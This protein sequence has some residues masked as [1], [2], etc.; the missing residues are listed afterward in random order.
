[1][2]TLLQ[3][4]RFGARLLFK[5]RGFTAI[6]V[7]TLALGIGPNMAIFSVINYILLNPFPFPNSNQLVAVWEKP[8]G[9]ERNEVAPANFLD[10]STQSD[11]F[12]SMAALSFWNANLTGPSLPERLQGFQVSPSLFPMLDTKPLMGRYFL[13]DEDTPGR[14]TVVILSHALWQNRFGSDPSI[15]NQTITLNGIPHTVV[16][17][18]PPSF[19]IYRR[20][21]L[22]VPL[23][24]TQEDRASRDFHFLIVIGRLKPSVTITQA[25]GEMDSIANRLQQLYPSTNTD[26]GIRLID[27]FDQTVVN[28]R[29]A[30]LM[31]LAA[32]AFVL[33]IAC[34]NLANLLLAR[35]TA[36][37]REIAIRVAL[38]SSRV[39]LVRQLL[40]ESVLLS[41]LGGT[42]GT[43]IAVWGIKLLIARIP[44]DLLFTVP[45]LNEIGVDG[46]ALAFTVAI[47]VLTG[48][49]FGLAPALHAS[50]PN[51]TES[52]KEGGRGLVGDQHGRVLRSGLVVSEIAV[53]VVLLVSIGL[54]I[55]SFVQ[56]LNVDTGF[57]PRN[58]LT[59]DFSLSG[60]KYEKQ[61]PPRAEFYR[62]VLERVE[63]VPGVQSVGATSNLPLGGTNLARSF[64]IEDFPVSDP[65]NT[66]SI[67]YRVVSP[68]YFRTLGIPLVKGRDFSRQDVADAPGV[69]IINESTMRRY[70][71]DQEPLGR[72][73][74][75]GPPSSPRPWLAIVGVVKDVKHVGLEEAPTAEVYL[76]YQQNPLT[77]MTLVARTVGDPMSIVTAVRGE[78]VGVDKEQPVYNVR[79]MEQVMSDSVPTQKLSVMLVGVFGGV[80][81]LLVTVGVYG[82]MSYTI[83]QRKR[84][85]GIRMALGAKPS[86]VVKMVLAQ[87]MLLVI[88][89]LGIGIALAIGVAWLL[90]SWLLG[91]N[92][93]FGVSATDPTTFIS[94][95][96]LLVAV[97]LLAIYIPAWTATKVDPMKVLREG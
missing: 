40:T 43:L 24:F 57:D 9:A 47:S 68:D 19:Q 91:T 80:A 54:V 92:L 79:S 60:E 22:W 73:I 83:G 33:L 8:V 71:P 20:S 93:L 53:S 87:G 32:V 94:V 46:R 2:E 30:I 1:M 21:D 85:I 5:N 11:S 50:K 6:A 70:W 49:I 59:M 23:S 90:I 14:N 25:Q 34:V 78:V 89:G 64:T 86:D 65:S 66:P 41:L 52:L 3:D 45:R 88:V 67:N 44:D 56:L 7:L 81:L 74:K 17:V 76:P 97:G 12:N 63:S 26:Q 29:P 75:I 4:L 84:E 18:M 82:V 38:G 35:A 10:W 48:I 31:L 37:Q 28:I 72:R 27:L 51:L 42:A 58:T 36:R 55:R 96:L 62:Q 69:A 77:D 95:A 39:R 61:R 16:G 15:V 13:P